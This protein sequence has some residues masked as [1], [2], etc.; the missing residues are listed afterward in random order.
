MSHAGLICG[1][2]LWRKGV[3]G[4]IPWR[5]P[6]GR[7]LDRE[8]LLSF[9]ARAKGHGETGAVAND[10]QPLRRPGWLPLPPPPRCRGASRLDRS[11]RLDP[12]TVGP[13]PRGQG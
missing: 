12:R 1:L 2:I 11:L 7:L 6:D 3:I 8:R 4:F 9:A 13:P 5:I 10:P